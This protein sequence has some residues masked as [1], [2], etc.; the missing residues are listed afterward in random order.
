MKC[1]NF[2]RVGDNHIGVFLSLADYENNKQL[3]F[4]N[5]NNEK[6]RSQCVVYPRD[7][8]ITPV[9]LNIFLVN[10]IDIDALQHNAN[11]DDM[12]NEINSSF[13]NK[14]VLN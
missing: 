9:L 11:L 2:I 13:N 12:V 14:V 6:E 8:K 10:Y 5:K 7:F 3:I 1:N 4:F